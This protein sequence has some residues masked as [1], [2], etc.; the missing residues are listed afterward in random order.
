MSGHD[1]GPADLE[2]TAIG[3]ALS[4]LLHSRGLS[5]AAVL[6]AVLAA[7]PEAVGAELA[8]WVRPVALRGDELVVEVESSPWATQ[9]ALLSDRLLEELAM[10]VGHPVASRLSARVNPRSER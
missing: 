10:A 9:V 2:L 5:Q 3:E 1:D 6:A 7:W 8:R 4:S